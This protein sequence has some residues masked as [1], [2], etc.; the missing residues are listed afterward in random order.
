MYEQIPVNFSGWDTLEPKKV[1]ELC[2]DYVKEAERLLNKKFQLPI[3]QEITLKN[4]CT[5][6]NAVQ[7]EVNTFTKK[8]PPKLNYK[9]WIGFPETPMGRFAADIYSVIYHLKND[10]RT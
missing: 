7:L 5:F 6:C 2:Q 10:E 8:H 4:L 1:L 9:I 3:P